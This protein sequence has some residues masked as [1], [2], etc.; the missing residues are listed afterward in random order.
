[1]RGRLDTV[2]AALD[3]GVVI[4]GADTAIIEANDRARM[5]LG[6]QD[7]DG[8]TA[9]DPLW[10]FLESDQSPMALERFPVM[11]VLSS[12]LPLW[13]QSMIVRRPEGPDVWLEVNA[14]PLTDDAGEL[15]EVVVT[16]V[17]VT[18][19]ESQKR[20]VQEALAAVQASSDYARRLIET[21]LDPLVTISPDGMITDVN[22]ATETVT[23]L[24]RSELIGTEFSAY[25]T[26]PDEARAGYEQAF[27][28]GHVVDY[29]LAV[30]HTSG[31]VIPVL[32]N[33]S[34]YR[35]ERGDVVGV[36]AAA[37]D[38]TESTATADALQQSERTFRLAMDGSPQGMAVV[39]LGL[40][41]LKVNPVLCQMLGRDEAWMLSHSMRD[42]VP[43]EDLD[44]DLARYDELYT[45]AAQRTV[46]EGRWLRADGST[47]WT[48]HSIALLRDEHDNPVSY[49]SQMHDNADAHRVR[50]DLLARV[51][52]DPLTGLINREQLQAHIAR[53]LT[54]PV[55]APGALAVLFCD[56]D[57]FKSI[58]D[59]YGHAAGDEVL[60]VAAHRIAS[61]IRL[62][63]VAARVGGDEFV[64]VLETV[65]DQ[66]AAAAVAEK[67][68]LAIAEPIF[69]GTERPICVTASVGVVLATTQIDAHRLLRN[70]D[71]A[72]YAA[73]A[74]GR[75]RVHVFEDESLT[76]D[77]RNIRNALS[78][79]EFV[80]WFQPV[81][82]L[83]DGAL[84]GYEALA[85]WV[86]PDGRVITPDSFLTEAKRSELIVDLD[87]VILERSLAVLRALPAPLHIAVNVS[88]ASLSLDNFADLVI[89]AVTRSGADPSRL[90][91]EFTET[92]LL[93]VTTAVR[94]TMDRLVEFGIR[95]YVDDF[96]TGYSSISHLRDM[97]IAGLKLDL[98]FTAQLS[99]DDPNS[100][101][102]AKAL[103]GLAAGLQLDTI[104]EGVETPSQA[105]IL[106]AEGWKH[107]QG[108]LYGRPV[109]DLLVAS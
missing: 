89:A 21:S 102:L 47:L 48:V 44:A 84:V 100:E 33:A 71:I 22:T 16:F 104:A 86:D 65:A 107:G 92:D 80:P 30:R 59:T 50:E 94:T 69:I 74:A 81:V 97:P 73:K 79:A 12:R 66:G 91:L 2:L 98:S 42:V 57:D 38:V 77:A 75:D 68:R 103:A 70:A 83:D 46:H 11:Q 15:T 10:V 58:N 18:A 43:A 8:R 13:G 106:T 25:F 63:D 37:R 23:G 62:A 4:H 19:E 40:Q 24:A 41:F 6:L 60:R 9:T 95:W 90:R 45:G 1:M 54:F 93:T 52:H 108:Y 39:S 53:L 51:N 5:L 99:S 61:S 101:R 76:N 88:A 28:D 3:A 56:I 87:R 72:L 26:C 82:S 34:V 14:L 7:L 55:P 64:A 35:N 85:R 32:Y 36:F 20:A 78:K 27:R 49:V 96:G 29:P 109:S 17:D 67:I 31:R 105:A